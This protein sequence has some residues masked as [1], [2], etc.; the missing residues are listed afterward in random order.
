M[1][2]KLGLHAKG[3][4]LST[5]LSKHT[6]Q[7]STSVI[8]VNATAAVMGHA[9]RAA[10]VCCSA[11]AVAFSK[12]VKACA[13]ECVGATPRLEHMHTRCNAE[14]TVVNYFHRTHSHRKTVSPVPWRHSTGRHLPS[15]CS[16]ATWPCC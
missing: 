11:P 8:L 9:R 2:R 6:A 7:L 15:A 5:Q 10:Q 3:R 4:Q 1:A 13:R 16:L 14:A 12:I